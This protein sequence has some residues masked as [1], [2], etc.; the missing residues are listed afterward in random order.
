MTKYLIALIAFPTVLAPLVQ[1]EG[2]S[3]WVSGVSSA[4][5]WID[6]NKAHVPY[7]GEDAWEV[8]NGNTNSR[9]AWSSGA[10][11]KRVALTSVAFPV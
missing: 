10:K 1:A 5:G 2:G 3:A 7:S 8:G 9:T 6:V 4:S 11:I